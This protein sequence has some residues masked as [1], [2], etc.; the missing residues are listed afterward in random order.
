VI[1]AARDI[2]KSHGERVLFRDVSFRVGEGD[3]IALVGQNG[4]GKTTILDIVAGLLSPDGGV[5]DRRRDAS[6]GYLQQHAG[7]LGDVAVLQE[8]LGAA[9]DVEALQARIRDLEARMD[10]LRGVELERVL[11]EYGH[12]R[13]RFERLGGYTVEARARSILTGLGFGEEDMDRPCSEFSGGWTMRI[14]LAKVLMG[15]PDL[16]LLDEPTNHLDLESLRWLESF[17]RQYPGAILLVSHDRAFLDAL[18]GR[19]LELEFGRAREWTGNYSD[20]ARLKEAD[21]ERLE[22]EYK[23]QQRYIAQQERFIERFRYKAKK[24][25]QVQ[26]RIKAL[27]KLERIELPP[28][29]RR[30][31]F[32]FPQPPR[33]GKEVVSLERVRKAYGDNVVYDTLDLT[34]YRGDRV[35][36]VGPNG[37]GKSTL[38]K[39][40]AGAID[41]DS[42]TRRLGHHVDVAYFA[43]RQSEALDDSRTVLQEIETATRGWEESRRR[44]LAGTFLFTGRDVDKPISVLSGGERAKVALAKMLAE[45]ASLLC[46]DEPTNHLDIA[47]RDVLEQALDAYTGA[48]VLIT[49]DRHLMRAITNKIIEVVDGRLTVYEGDYDY[50]L[51]KS[52]QE[53][54]RSEP[55]GSEEKRAGPKPADGVRTVRGPGSVAPSS[56]P[57]SKEQRRRE[58]EARNAASRATRKHRDAL[59]ALD[60][61]MT[62]LTVRKRELDV[63]L[64]EETTYEDRTHFAT[65]VEEYGR[66]D[67]RLAEV[68]EEWLERSAEIER[69]ITEAPDQTS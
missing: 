51:F 38:L 5:V 29:K 45:P 21:R 59:A 15:E 23:N 40:L 32:E 22:R 65:L 24:A 33:T 46:V 48:L 30:V 26:S 6:I 42:G 18:V 7:E 54:A 68:E 31:R 58:A 55:T 63:L 19:V 11:G 37:A 9:E 62:A 17:L 50:Y 27:E 35:A 69:I 16:L 28:A 2:G 67:A 44:S 39:L 61:E 60:A 52:G 13:E 20:Y 10:G 57:K 49:H 56:A 43:Q 8:V 47:S 53:G 34:V 25:P 1:L 12:A 36:L 66:V 4:S 41:P 64:A 14:S 3:R